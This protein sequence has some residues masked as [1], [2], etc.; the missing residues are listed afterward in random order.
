[1][2]KLIIEGDER[3]RLR[4]SQHERQPAALPPGMT[5]DE[6]RRAVRVLHGFHQRMHSM[7]EACSQPSRP[8]TPCH[9]RIRVPARARARSRGAGRPAARRSAV[10]SSASSG[11]SGPGDSEPASRRLTTYAAR[12]AVA[13]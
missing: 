8:K 9:A 4:V 2:V 1:M 3:A 11:D 7:R 6:A 5:M 12:L 10:R 13:A